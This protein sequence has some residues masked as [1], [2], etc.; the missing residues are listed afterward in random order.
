[1]NGVYFRMGGLP[2]YGAR[3]EDF[4]FLPKSLA[5]LFP[6]EVE[7]TFSTGGSGA[8]DDAALNRNLVKS[9]Q[10]DTLVVLSLACRTQSQRTYVVMSKTQIQ[11]E[12]QVD[13]L[14]PATLEV[15]AAKTLQTDF[16][17]LKG[18]STKFP[19]ALKDQLAKR[20]AEAIPVLPY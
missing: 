17:E 4:E 19:P 9:Y 10:P 13:F 5:K 1:M 7:V 20:L 18:T 6:P 15:L 8:A 12:L 14:A 2:H 3:L 16:V 11:A